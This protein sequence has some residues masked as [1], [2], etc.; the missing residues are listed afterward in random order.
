VQYR[1]FADL[2]ETVFFHAGAIP[3]DVD[4]VVGVPRSGLLPANLLA[5]QLHKPLLDLESYLQGRT[6]TVGRTARQ[7]IQTARPRRVLIVDDSIASGE[8]MRAVR[9][10][11]RAAA[12]DVPAVYLAVYGT[13]AAHAEVDL[14]FEA[15]AS[16][17]IFEWNLMR[18][19]RLADS[20][21]DIDGVL[22]HDPA[23][24]QN[25]DGERY[26]SFLLTAKPLLRANVP[27]KHLVTSRLEKYRPETERWLMAHGIRY[28]HLWMLDLPSAEERRRQRAHARFKASVYIRTGA[29]L[30]VESEDR[31]AQEIAELSSRPVLSIE[32][33]RMVWPDQASAARRSYVRRHETNGATAKRLVRNVVSGV[34]GEQT[35]ARIKRTL[36][37]PV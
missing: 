37:R 22:C 2:A 19:K 13:R 29:C 3:D 11:V 31:Q 14:V 25:D 24:D 27:I 23:H 15:V 26:R 7:T 18:H 28:E 1:S 6:P 32:G 8:S 17:R 30:F 12:P 9:D 20:C 4:L 16:P 35:I 5:L 34:F 10:R 36:N 21:F 33:Q